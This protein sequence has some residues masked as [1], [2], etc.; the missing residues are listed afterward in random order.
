MG[1]GEWQIGAKYIQ[2]CIDLSPIYADWYHIPLCVHHYRAGHYAAALREARKIRLKIVWGPM[3]R[4]VLYQ[5]NDLKDKPYTELG[6]LKQDHPNFIKSGH[7]LAWSFTH[8]TN[9]VVKQLLQDVPPLE[10][11]DREDKDV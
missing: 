2:D 11:E 8:D 7:D 4:T 1:L 9:L 5:R 10:H 6:K 3:L